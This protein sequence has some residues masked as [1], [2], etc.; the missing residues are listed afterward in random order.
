MLIARRVALLPLIFNFAAF[1][2]GIRE[3]DFKNLDYGW[4]APKLG[5]PDTWKWLE[6]EPKSTALVVVGRCD[7]SSFESPPGSYRGGYLAI[8]SV[9]YGDLNNDGQE[10]AAVDVL[11]S[12]GGTLNWHY[13]YVFTLQ[14]GLPKLLGRLQSGSRADGG[15][16]KV[17]IVEGTLVLDFAD[18]RRRVV[19]CCSAG[20]VRVRY[21]WQG[22]HFV[23]SGKPEFG[24]LDF[25]RR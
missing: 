7:F 19:D 3:V 25:G 8:L 5:A 23:E 12:T 14:N 4:D 1:C 11:Y 24:D 9:A 10:D 13:V 15:L 18:T 17:A 2:A 6:R 20:Y 22:G 21:R 16:V